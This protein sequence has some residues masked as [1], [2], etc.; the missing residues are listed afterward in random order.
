MQ[1]DVKGIGARGRTVMT[2]YFKFSIQYDEPARHPATFSAVS[3]KVVKAGGVTEAIFQRF[4]V[5]GIERVG[6]FIS[7]RTG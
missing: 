4:S 6:D 2:A 7:A 5:L 3:V 1:V